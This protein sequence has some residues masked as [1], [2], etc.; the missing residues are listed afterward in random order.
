VPTRIVSNIYASENFFTNNR[1]LELPETPFDIIEADES[2]NKLY[3]ASSVPSVTGN[4]YIYRFLANYVNST[5]VR[6]LYLH[7]KWVKYDLGAYAPSSISITLLNTYV[8]L[9]DTSS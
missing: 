8:S 9:R 3:A 7:N 4:N 6:D 1:Y 2:L 5:T